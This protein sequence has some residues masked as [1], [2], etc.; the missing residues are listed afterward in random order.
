MKYIASNGK[1]KL[2]FMAYDFKS[3]RYT[4]L[5]ALSFMF[6]RQKGNTKLRARGSVSDIT[7]DYYY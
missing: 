3:L 1:N 7:K 6:Q 5:E 2:H 4:K